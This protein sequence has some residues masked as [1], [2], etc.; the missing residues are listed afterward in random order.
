L[1]YAHLVGLLTLRLSSCKYSRKTYNRPQLFACPV[2]KEFM[3]CDYRKITA[4]LDDSPD[5]AAVIELKTA[6]HFTALQK[7]ASH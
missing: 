5:L 6:P 7:A 2:I 1:Q 4:L 3:Q